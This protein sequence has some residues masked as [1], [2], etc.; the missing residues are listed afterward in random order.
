MSSDLM[1]KEPRGSHLVHGGGGEG[2]PGATIKHCFKGSA[3]AL[4]EPS[5]NTNMHTEY[6]ISHSSIL[7][8]VCSPKH[9]RTVRHLI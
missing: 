4:I 1:L 6:F 9:S 8:L 7:G 2:N 3:D 5:S